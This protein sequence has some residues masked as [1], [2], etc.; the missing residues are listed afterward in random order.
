[1]S[2]IDDILT[3]TSHWL[4]KNKNLAI[5]TVISTWG[6]SPRQIGGQ[7]TVSSEGDFIGS[8]SGGCVETSIIHVAQETI[9]DRKTRVKDYGISNEMAWEVGLACGGELKILINPLDIND[10]IIIKVAEDIK[11]RN[12]VTLIT[13]CKT[14][15][16]K[17]VYSQDDTFRR[18][19]YFDKEN[20]IFYL[21]ILPKPI[22]YIIGAVHITESLS[23]MAIVCGYEVYIID[24]RDH[25]TKSN[26]FKNI[27]IINEWPDVALENKVFD[28]NC[29]LVTLTHDPKIDD[30]AIQ[31]G[32]N[33]NI[34]YIGCLGSKATQEKRLKRLKNLGFKK[35]E[36]DKIHG[37]V[38]LDIFSKTP[39]EISISILAEL[40]KYRRSLND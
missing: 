35:N 14:G 7:M 24:P 3:P 36:L 27:N 37:P 23:K 33:N 17:L 4:K 12:P 21:A 6:S 28:D 10:E 29:H 39:E 32:L 30:I 5:A 9:K 31:K 34:G 11:K 15:S 38:G 18:K 40:T 19:S 1:M 26:K 8:V 22:L 25:F 13:N 20:N 16:R 2:N